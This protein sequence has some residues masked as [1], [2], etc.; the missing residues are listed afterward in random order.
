MDVIHIC[1][2]EP[3]RNWIGVILKSPHGDILPHAINCE[4]NA[5]NNEAK[6][7]VLIMGL[8]LDKDL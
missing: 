8:Q 1:R 3:K 5:T 7:K 4:F 2:I 6:Y